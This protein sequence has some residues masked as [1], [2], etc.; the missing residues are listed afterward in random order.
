ME[1][2]PEHMW[3]SYTVFENQQSRHWIKYLNFY[4]DQLCKFN[5]NTIDCIRNC[6]M[7]I[8]CNCRYMMDLDKTTQKKKKQM[9]NRYIVAVEY[10]LWKLKR[11]DVRH[12]N[13]IRAICKINGIQYLLKT[14]FDIVYEHHQERK[15]PFNSFIFWSQRLSIYPKFHHIIYTKKNLHLLMHGNISCSNTE[16]VVKCIVEWSKYVRYTNNSLSHSKDYL[17][18]F[19]TIYQNVLVFKKYLNNDII[20]II[21]SY[22]LDNIRKYNRPTT[23]EI[24]DTFKKYINIQPLTNTSC[25]PGYCDFQ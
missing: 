12:Q 23:D 11:Y 1:T 15:I 22:L 9:K 14:W 18:H 10:F 21:M 19:L 24:L 13:F 16:F 3:S 4:F 7:L 17:I 20:S 8:K 2:F 5:Y 25:K 6:E